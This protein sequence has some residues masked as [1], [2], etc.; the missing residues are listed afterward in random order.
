[1]AAKKENH[2]DRIGARRRAAILKATMEILRD[3]G[4][5]AVTSRRIAEGAGLKSKLVHYYFKSMDELYL[6]VYREA[7]QQY[8]ERQTKAL[9]SDNPVRAL[10]ELNA[11]SYNTRVLQELIALASHHEALRVEIARA[12]HRSRVVQAIAIE[13]A[14]GNLPKQSHAFPPQLLSMLMTAAARLMAMDKV[15]GVNVGHAESK[16]WINDLLNQLDK[17]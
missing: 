3:E 1:M 10:W 12:S 13:K 6:A 11:D 2:P 16:K 9:V 14:I 7:E 17:A 15:L 5:G 8:Y 4:Y